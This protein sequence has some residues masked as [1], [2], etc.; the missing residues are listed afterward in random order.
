MKI[1]SNK[2]AINA[3]NRI[4]ANYLIIDDV[5]TTPPVTDAICS[6]KYLDVLSKVI[7]NSIELASI[8]GG[9]KGLSKLR[10]QVLENQSSSTLGQRTHD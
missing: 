5:L 6:S 7:D 4:A 9:E 8:I 3:I 2:Q 1:L 10:T